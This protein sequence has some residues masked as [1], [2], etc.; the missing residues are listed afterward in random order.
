MLP[1]SGGEQA[2]LD[3]A[4]AKPVDNEIDF[5]LSL[6]GSYCLFILLGYDIVRTPWCW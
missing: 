6:A 1:K 3:V 5:L 2:Y 4:F